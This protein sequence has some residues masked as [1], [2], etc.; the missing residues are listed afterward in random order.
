MSLSNFLERLR[1]RIL[2]RR[3]LLKPRPTGKLRVTRLE[4]RK[5][6]DAGFGFG[7]GDI[8]TLDGFTAGPDAPALVIDSA[9][10]VLTFEL[11]N[12][13]WAAG[14]LAGNAAFSLSVDNRTLS[15]DT[16]VATVSGIGVLAGD[17]VSGG[18]SLASVSNGTNGIEVSSLTITN[19]GD[20]TLNNAGNDFDTIDVQANSFTFSDTDDVIIN[21]LSVFA[22]ATL[23]AGGS[24]TDEAGST[25]SVGDDSVFSGSSITLGDSVGDSATFG[26]LK[27]VSA[28][29]VAI[30]EADD[31]DLAVGSSG[32]TVTL[33]A[34]GD[35]DGAAGT[36]VTADTV[37]FTANDA[38]LTESSIGADGQVTTD[39]TTLHASSSGSQHFGDADSVD[40]GLLS[41]NGTINLESGTFVTDS[42]TAVT[43]TIDLGSSA[44]LG[45]DGTVGDLSLTDGDFSPGNSPGVLNTGDFDLGTAANLDIELD[46]TAIGTEYDQVNVTGT[47]TLAGTLTVI[48]GFT[49][50]ANDTFTII[51][52]DDMDAVVGTF[53]GLAEGAVFVAGGEAFQISYVGVDG[54]DVVLTS[55]KHVYD[56]NA[57]NVSGSESGTISATLNRSGNT[58]VASSVEV[59]I[60]VGAGASAAETTDFT[61]ETVTV[62]FAAGATSATVDVD[63]TADTI[64]EDNE[65]VSL[66]LQNFSAGGSAGTTNASS[67]VTITNDDTAT[68]TI[69]NIAATETN[70]DQ[71]LTATVTLSA[72]V[73]G[74]ISVAYASAAVTA[75]TTDFTVAGT[76]VAFDGTAGEE[77]TISVTIGGDQIVEDNETFTIT[78][79]DVTAVSAVQDAAITTGAVSSGSIA[80]DDTATLS[81]G[82]STVNEA[83]G[84]ATFTITSSNASEKDLAFDVRLNI[85]TATGSDVTLDNSSATINGDGSTT[86]TTVTVSIADDQRVEGDENYSLTITNAKFD[87]VVDTDRVV[88]GAGAGTGDGVVT[89]NDT[90]TLS[91]DT[92]ANSVDEDNA[93]VSTGVTL[94]LNTSGTGTVG[95]DQQVSVDVDRTAGSAT[96]GG[97]EPDATYTDTTLT[98]A[99][100][101]GDSF[102]KSVD[103]TIFDDIQN[104]AGETVVL[105]LQDLT[106]GTSGQVSLGTSTHTLT[107]TDDDSA[108]AATLD[109]VSGAGDVE[110]RLDSLSGTILQVYVDGVLQSSRSLASISQLTINGTA[111]DEIVTVDASTGAFGTAI[112]F[113]GGD[114]ADIL[115]VRNPAAG[116]Y[117][118]AGGI[119]FNGND[120]AD[121]LELLGGTATTIEHQFV[122][123]SDG[124]VFYNGEA[125]ATVVYTGLAPVIDTIAATNRIFTF[126]GGAETIDVT[127]AAAVGQTTI[128]STLGESVSFVS[129]S[130][131]LTINAGTGDD[132]INITG[133][134]SL[135]TAAITINGDAGTDIINLGTDLG[136]GSATSTGEAVFNVEATNLTA[137]VTIGTNGG[138]STGDLTFTGTL[139]GAFDLTANVGGVTTFVSTVGASTALD[140]ITTDAAGSVVVGGNV[141]ANT[142]D[143][144]ETSGLSLTANAEF[145]ATTVDIE[146]GISGAFTLTLDGSTSVNVAGT[147]STTNLTTQTAATVGSVAIAG[148]LAVGGGQLTTNVGAITVGG[149][150]VSTAAISAAT[151]LSVTGTSSIGGNVTSVGEQSYSSAVTQTANAIY[152]GADTDADFEAIDFRS[153]LA[154]GG[155]SVTIVG[156]AGF[157]SAVSGVTALA[158]DHIDSE[159]TISAASVSVTGTSDLGGAVTTSG[160]QNYDGAVLLTNSVTLASTGNAAISLDSTVNGAF[161]LVVNTTGVTTFGG[162]VGG[163]SPLSSLTTNAGGTTAINGGTVTTSG[164]QSYND[165]VT[166]AA[167]TTTTGVGLTFGSTVDGNF[168]LTADGG[169]GNV[170]FAGA[171]GGVTTLSGLVVDGADVNFDSTVQIDD[172]G[173]DVDSTDALSFDAAVTTTNGGTVTLSNAGVLTLAAAAD[174]NLDGAFVQDG[175]GTVTTAADIVTSGNA[176]SFASAVTQSGA[177]LLDTTNAGTV[178]SGASIALNTIAGGSNSLTLNG[179]SAGAMTSGQISGVGS[180]TIT[181]SASAT[182]SGTVSAATVAITDTTGNVTFNDAVTATSFTAAASSFG[183]VFNA[184]GTIA[185]AVTLNN[186]GGVTFGNAVGDT[187]N[188][189]NGITS[190]ASTTTIQGTL[191]TTNSN[192]TF[193]ATTLAAAAT[194]NTGAGGGNINFGQITGGTNS[195]VVNAGTG[196]VSL[197]NAG[198]VIGGLTVTAAAAT[199]TEAD[200]ITQSAAWTTTGATTLNAG[201]NDITLTNAANQFGT[202]NLTA[203]NATIRENADIEIGSATITT[204]IDLT[205]TGAINDATTDGI[206]DITATS[207]VLT[208]ATG[209][210]SSEELEISATNITASST[211]GNIDLDSA[212]ATAVNVATLVTGSGTID[213]D[214]LGAGGVDFSGPVTSG[215]G[216]ISL[217]SDSGLVVGAVVSSAGTAGG[218]LSV[219]GATLN[220]T[221]VVG[222]DITIAGGSVDTVIAAD[223]ANAGDLALSALRDV[224]IS[225]AISTT[226]G[227]N[228]TITADSDG[229][230]NTGG[231]GSALGG[232]LIAADGQLNSAGTVGVSGSD[233]LNGATAGTGQSV[234]VAADGTND[235]IVAVGDIS[236]TGNAVAATADVVI[237]GLVTSTTGDISVTSADEIQTATKIEATAGSIDFNDAVVLTGGTTIFAGT[238]ATFDLT[239]DGAFDLSLDVDGAATFVGAVGATTAIGDGTGAAI[240]IDGDGTTEFQSAVAT[241]SGIAQANNAGAVTFRNNINAA[242]GD[243][244]SLFAG[245]VVLDGLAF[246]SGGTI[247]FGNATTDTLT[248]SA[249][250][251]SISTAAANADVVFDAATIAGAD[252]TVSVG[253]GGITVNSVV[254][255]NSNVV[256]NSAG[257]TD[258]NAAIGS[259]T[260]VGSLTTDAPGSTTLAANVTAQGGTITIN[261]ALVLNADVILA[262]SGATGIFLN[263][264]VDSDSTARDLTLTTTNAAATISIGN[265]ASD[266]VGGSSA[267]D[268]LSVSAAGT[269]VQAA[270]IAGAAELTYDAVGAILVTGSTAVAGNIDIDSGSTIG[271]SNTITTTAGGTVNIDGTGL[272][273]LSS[274]ADINSDGAVSFGAAK[275]GGLSTGGDITTTNDAITFN[276]P[277]TLTGDVILN[278]GAGI[279][280]VTFSSPNGTVNG[281]RDLTISAGTGNVE[282]DA[283]I[284]ASAALDHLNVVL[285]NQINFDAAITAATVT[286]S[287]STIDG[288]GLVAANTIDLDAVNGIGSTTAL[289][290]NAVT[291]DAT[292]TTSGVI[293]I[294]EADSVAVG[295][296][297]NGD[298]AVTL[299]AGGSVTDGNGGVTNVTAGLF[300]V[301]AAGGIDLDTNVSTLAATNT[302]SGSISIDEADGVA[303]DTINNAN[304]TVTLTAGGAITDAGDANVDIVAGTASVTITGAG[305][306]G[307]SLNSIETTVADLTTDT[308]TSGGSQFITETDGLTGININ[309][310]AGNVTLATGAAIA[311]ADAAID[312]V[313]NTA[314]L[315]AVGG[316]GSANAI[317]TNIVTLNSGNTSGGDVRIAEANDL[318]LGSIVNAADTVNIAAVGSI[319]DD[320]ANTAADISADTIQLSAGTGIGNLAEVELNSAVVISAATTAGDIDIDHSADAAVTASSLTT[321]GAGG[322]IDFDQ[323]GNHSLTLTTVSTTNGNV[324]ISN[325]GGLAAAVLVGSITADTSDD[326]VAISSSSSINDASANPDSTADIT[327]A[328]VDLNAVTGI[329]NTAHL[330]LASQTISADTTDGNIDIDNASSTATVVS[331]LTTGT[332]N[333]AFNQSGGGSVSFATATTAAGSIDL[334]NTGNDLIVATSVVAAGTGDVVLT[335]TTAGDVIVNGAVTAADDSVTIASAEAVSGAALITAAT[336]NLDANSGIGSGSAVNLAATTIA[337]DNSSADN[338]RINN[339]LATAVDVTSLT[340][341]GGAIVFD[342][343]GGGDVV[344]SGPVTSG[345]VATNGGDISLTSSAG[346]EVSATST[347][348]SAAGSGGTLTIA[349]ATVNG[350][351]T[352]GEGDVSIQ[353]GSVD[354]LVS[355][356]LTSDADITLTAERDVIIGGVVSANSGASIVVTSDTNADTDS[357]SGPA[358]GHGGVQITTAGQ[359]NA[360]GTITVTGSD[361]FATGADV[362]SVLVQADG[363]NAQVLAVGSIVIGDGSNAPVAAAVVVDGLVQT[364]GTASTIDVTSEGNVELGSFGDVQAVD[365][366]VT[367]TADTRSGNNG[368]QVVMADGAQIRTTAGDITVL[369]DGN[370]SLGQLSTTS[371]VTVTSDSGAITDAGDDATYDIIAA[372]SA[373]SALIGIGDD[374]NALETQTA[375]AAST[376]TIAALTDSGDINIA[377]AG[378]LT[379]GTVGGVVGITISDDS[380]SG[381]DAQDSTLDNITLVAASPLTVNAAITNN[382]GSNII[383]TS[384]NDGGLDDHL[385]INAALTVTG[386]DAIQDATGNI[387]LNAGTDL[388]VNSAAATDAAGTITGIAARDVQLLNTSTLTT[389][390][391]DASL[392]ATA[393][394]IAMADG[395]AL[396]S[397]TGDLDLLA[398]SNVALS[399]VTTTANVDVTA[400]TGSIADAGDSAIDVAANVA[401]FTAATGI[402]SGNALETTVA[403]LNATNSTSGTIEFAETDDLAIGIVSNG[404]RNVTISAG[405]NITDANAAVVNVTAGLF[406]VDA[407]G[408]IDLDTSISSLDASTSAAGDID[409][410]ETDAITL[411]DV[412]TADGMIRVVAAGTITA[413]DVNSAAVDDDTNDILLTTTTGDI[414]VGL[415]NAGGNNDVALTAAAAISESGSDAAVDLLAGDAELVADSGIGNGNA[416]ETTLTNLAFSNSTS[417]AVQITNSQSLT[418]A[419]VGALA[420][421]SNAAGNIELCT[422]SGDLAVNSAL[423]ATGNT[424]RLG[425]AS[426]VTQSATGIISANDLAVRATGDILLATA[427]AGNNVDD[428]FAAASTTSGQIQF[429]DNGGFTVGTV[430]AAAVNVGDCFTATVGVQTAAGDVKLSSDAGDIIVN[431]NVTAGGTGDATLTTTTS[432]NVTVT[433]VVSSANTVSINSAGEIVG[434][435]TNTAA[436]IVANTVTLTAV[437]GIGDAPELELAATNISAVSDNGNIDLDNALATATTVSNLQTGAGTIT[438][439]QSGG[440]AVEFTTVSTTDGTID[441][442]NGGSDLTVGTSVTA[443]GTGDLNLTTTGAGDVVLTGVATAADN[444]ITIN[445]ADLIVGDAADTA[446]DLVATNLDLTAVNGIGVAQPLETSVANLTFSNTSGPV[447]IANDQSLNLGA[448]TTAGDFEMCLTSG[449]LTISDTLSATGGTVRLQ[450]SAGS[451]IESGAGEILATNLGVNASGDITLGAATNAVNVFAAES[452]GGSIVFTEV[453]GFEVGFLMAGDCFDGATGVQT[454]FDTGTITL[455]SGGNLTTL[456]IIKSVN[457]ETEIN[458]TSGFLLIGGSVMT[459]G[460]AIDV[461]TVGSASVLSSVSSVSG[462]I[463]ITSTGNFVDN[464]APITT[465]SGDITVFGSLGVLSNDE[466]TSTSGDIDVSGDFI[467]QDDIFSTGV[468]GTI[469]VSATSTVL[470][471][472]GTS[473]TTDAGAIVYSSG[474]NAVISQ[475]TTGSGDIDVDAT[476][477]TADLNELIQSTTGSIDITGD[478]V[479]Q[480]ANIM[481]GGAGTIDVTADNGDITMADGTV[482]TSADGNITYDATNSIGLS[483]I[484]TAADA[485]VTA[486]SDSDNAGAITDNLTGEAAN[487]TA[488]ELALRAADGIGAADDIDTNV[489]LLAAVSESGSILL[490]EVDGSGVVIGTTDGLS[491][492]TITDTAAALDSGNDHIVV[493]SSGDIT[494]DDAVANNDHGNILLSAESAGSGIVA[495]AAISTQVGNIVLTAV[496]NVVLDESVSTTSTG[497]VHVVSSTGGI[498]VSDTDSSSSG[499]T[500]TGGAGD[501]LL[502]AATTISLGDNLDSGTGDVG[503]EAGRAFSQLANVSVTTDGGNAIVAADSISMAAGSSITTGVANGDIL[504]NSTTGDITVESLN[505]G[506]GHVAIDSAAD[507]VDQ[508]AGE[509]NNVTAATLQLTAAGS[510]GAADLANLPTANGNA[511][512]TSVDTLAATAASGIYVR[513]TNGITVGTTSTVSVTV[514]ANN[515]MLN[516]V[517]AGSTTQ[518]TGSDAATSDITTTAGPIKIVAD[519]GNITINDGD[520]DGFGINAG[521]DG[522]VLLEARTNSIVVNSDVR[523]AT[524]HMTLIAADDID[525]NEDVR[526]G[527]TGTIFLSA[528]DQLTVDDGADADTNGIVTAGGSVLVRATTA[529]VNA[530]IN[531][532]GGDFGI[533]LT[534]S[535][536][537]TGTMN[538]AGGDV[539]LT[540]G[541]DLTL[542]SLVAGTGT[543]QIEA[544]GNVIDGN[545]GTTIGTLNIVSSALRINSGRSIGSSDTGAADSVNANAIDVSVTTLA[546]NSDSGIYI[547][548]TDGLIVDAVASIAIDV[549]QVHFN[550]TD[551]A[552]NSAAATGSLADLTTATNGSI[553][554]VSLAG[555]LQLNEGGDGDGHAVSASGSGDVLIEARTAGDV[556]VSSAIESG[557]GHITLDAADDVRLN[558]TIITG[559]SGTVY[560]LAANANAA[561][562]TAA[563]VDGV[564]IAGTITTVDG[565]ILAESSNDILQ[566]ALITSTTGDVGHVATNDVVQTSSGDITTVDGDVLIDAGNDWTMDADAVITAGGQDVLGLA[567]NNITLGV[568]SLTDAGT[569][570]IALQAGADII[571]G[572]SG[573]INIQETIAAAATS[574][575]LRAGSAIGASD[576]ASGNGVDTNSNAIDLK[577]DTV[578]AMADDGIYLRQIASGGDIEINSAAAVTVSVDSVVRS[579]FNSTTTSVA[580]T[581]SEGSLESLLT[582]NTTGGAIKLVAEDGTIT[583]NESGTLPGFAVFAGA[584]GDILLE[585][586]GTNSDVIVNAQIAGSGNITLDADDDISVNSEIDAFL[587]GTIYL[588]AENQTASDAAVADGINVDSAIESSA[589]D[590]LLESSHDIRQNA[591]ISSL[592]GDIGLVSTNDITQTSTGDISTL[593]GDVLIDAGNDWTMA[594]DAII[595]AGGQ[596][597]LG[598]AGG[599]IVLGVISATDIN[600][601]HI[602]LSA[603]G[604]ITDANAGAVN[605]EET[606]ST[607]TTTLSLRAGTIVGGIGGGTATVN[608]DAIDLDI[609][610]IAASAVDGIFLREIGLGRAIEVNSVDA[611]LVDIEGIVRTN[612]DS[613]TSDVSE[614]RSIASLEDLT[615]TAGPIKL[616]AEAGAITINGGADAIGVTAGGANNVLLDAGTFNDV[617]INADVSSTG[618]HITVN[619]ADDVDVNATITTSGAGTVY[620]NAGNASAGDTAAP[621]VDGINIDGI[622]TTADGD[623]LLNSSQDIRTTQ[624]V[625]STTGDVGIIAARDIV[626]ENDGDIT[627]GGD[628]LVEAGNDWTMA[629]DAVITATGGEVDGHA[630]AGDLT[631]GLIN[632]TNVALTAEGSIIDANAGLLNVDA[633]TLSLQ[634]NTGLIGNHDNANGT[635]AAN[636]NAIDT[637]VT[638]LAANAEAGIYISEADAVVVD[639][640]NSVTVNVDAPVQVNFNDTTTAVNQSRTTAA[641]EDLTSDANGPVKLQTVAGTLTINGGTDGIGVVA[642]GTGDVLLQAVGSASDVIVNAEVASGTGNVTLNAGDDIAVNSAIT[643]TG[644]GSVFVV[645]GAATA[646]A[647]VGQVDGITLDAALTTAAGDVL[648]TSSQS[649]TINQA[650][651]S[652]TGDVG[653]IADQDITQANTGDITTGA[654]VLIEAGR[655]WTMASDAVITATGGEVDGHAI[656]GSINLGRINSTN[657]ALTAGQS[658]LD[659]NGALLNIDAT[660]VSLRADNGQVGTNADAID[661]QVTTLAANAETG[662]YILEADDLVIDTVAAVTVNVDSPL[663]VNFNSTTSDVAQ[664]RSTAVL[665]DLTTESNGPIKVVATGG[666]TVNGGTDTIAVSANGTG[667][668]LLDAN[669]GDLVINDNVQSGT[670][671]VTVE[672]A[673]QLNVGAA[674]GSPVVVQT[675]GTGSIVASAQS[676]D[677]VMQP[678]AHLSTAFGSIHI[679]AATDVVVGRITSLAN[680]AITATAGSITDADTAAD[681]FVDITANGLLLNSGTTIGDIGGDNAIETQVA[682]IAAESNGE[683]HV[684]EADALVIGSV[685]VDTQRVDFNGGT[686]AVVD[687]AIDGILSANSDILLKTGSTLDIVQQ[688]NAGSADVRIVSDATISQTAT[689]IVTADEL[690]IILTGALA[691]QNIELGGADNEL[692]VLAIRNDSEGGNATVF[693]SADDLVVGQI[694]SQPGFAV[695][696]GID[697]NAGDINI[698]AEGDLTVTEDINAA[699]QTLTTSIDESITLISRNGDFILNDNVVVTSDENPAPGEFDDVTGDQITIIAGSGGSNGVVRLGDNIEVRSDGGVAR[700]VAPRPTAFAV[701]PTTGAQSAFVTLSDAETMRSNLLF[702]NGAFLGELELV[703]GVAGE[704][705]LEVVI[706]WGVVTQTSLV[707][708]GPAGNATEI[709]PGEFAFGLDDGD[710][711]IFFIDEG[712]AAYTIPHLYDPAELL[713]TAN[714]RNGRQDNPNIVGVRFSVAQHESINIWGENA[715]DPAGVPDTTPPTF[716]QPAVDDAGNPIVPDQIAD[717]TGT[718]IQPEG[719]LALLSSTD[720]N[721]L[722]NFSQEATNQSLP[723]NDNRVVTSTGRPEGQAEW[724][725]LAG[726]SPGLVPVQQFAQQ[727]FDAPLVETP[728]IILTATEVPGDINLGDGAAGD[729]AVGTEVYLQIR[730]HFESDAEAEVVIARIT[731]NSFIANRDSFED[732][733]EQNPVLQ[734]GDGYEVWLITETGG[735][736]VARPIVE[737]EITGGRPGPATEELPDTFEPYELKE[738]EFEQPVEEPTEEQQQQLD[739]PADQPKQDEDLAANKGESAGHDVAAK[740]GAAETMVGQDLEVHQSEDAERMDS[741]AVGIIPL[742]GLSRAARWKRRQQAESEK[743]GRSSRTARRM[744]KMNETDTGEITQ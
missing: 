580:E 394:Q 574:V 598:S 485:I 335:T 535:G 105:S 304:R 633:T 609:D 162:V 592:D 486:D 22:D 285:A 548:E 448:A 27:F 82:N 342:Q 174:F 205:S 237:N 13:I 648:L 268:Q 51:N 551:T 251:V 677:V 18:D 133:I 666:L 384:T 134:D 493:R 116:V 370:V 215:G 708:S 590:I 107:I 577:V 101:D 622:I 624:L 611:V 142:I 305:D 627:T 480:D 228:I 361:V 373:L 17:G 168:L 117:D 71:N 689:G 629:A 127:D 576:L 359:L 506:T 248:T 399:S 402:G 327:S 271:I 48:P 635:P 112:I 279:G 47:V 114:G 275:V 289:N 307:T 617:I 584:A 200:D 145:D 223:L 216:A 301:D 730:R 691:D 630:V 176:I 496:D 310:G 102:T 738:L 104:D 722:R 539:L 81:I 375:A 98:F 66:T 393:G 472:A 158:A 298:R 235:Q 23:T 87:G 430:A 222:A 501:I 404:V 471:G 173:L 14:D 537:L 379:V 390:D 739:E 643:T 670:G 441:L 566:T 113:N 321:G 261:D 388:I 24:I 358:G 625:N 504:L 314:N 57:A 328:V 494:V 239:V 55:A 649:I 704:E 741:A 424:I 28:G 663:Q 628:V 69:S 455:T 440:G 528:V 536:G 115:R 612:F 517:D 743:F 320:S 154:G 227:G 398:Q 546:A 343:A 718:F 96:I 129:P 190:T 449:D 166:L 482:T 737:F 578:A 618:G 492:I 121:T 287:G 595:T 475:L 236:V 644:A 6:L 588:L 317:Q 182:F 713:T 153:T 74:G 676:A 351:V 569:N 309:A 391:G 172:E 106:D 376:H 341:V 257:I 473:A 582:T 93:T 62:N 198:N 156:G 461:N 392:T 497:S 32:S 458:V 544:G 229:I 604:S 37:A 339:V 217:T 54:N 347:V 716:Q 662:I 79:G 603:G 696:T 282:F 524:G 659:A 319:N 230:A 712:G 100:G 667:N 128:D 349:G 495:N 12:D 671:H 330:E 381:S 693:E 610:T 729:S 126:T 260:A 5:L 581:R 196:D 34:E 368:G 41:S 204:T 405:G 355:A 701:A 602:A 303:L 436:D 498:S 636:V 451:V 655:D 193:G 130:A 241:A 407:A 638:T 717:A 40:L 526:T 199:I 672:A 122:N 243:T 290:L 620:V 682:T 86:T 39:A 547:Q 483:Q 395:T 189:T 61:A 272:T 597:V 484:T 705:N 208:A 734:D 92:A 103:A 191:N 221:P 744:R 411:T 465:D 288:N 233:L 673:N 686:T 553:K 614:D 679:D 681:S 427:T 593:N 262:D 234:L 226:A 206:T 356:A 660:T 1:D 109:L 255:G 97:A 711:S 641:L 489:R 657:V 632:S 292:N 185:N 658:I 78:L 557:T 31:I 299:D 723:L 453:D 95:L 476:A 259:T 385:T 647:G 439:D 554:V 315:T 637:Q 428:V 194:V 59:V 468:S 155:N 143:L 698:T 426:N 550:S 520:A 75:E 274:A 263:N 491:G 170:V 645:S 141:S 650:I 308:S 254:D 639:S 413:V 466:I 589:G 338:V 510:I 522:D 572:N 214:H 514:D 72:A 313:A 434:D 654:D 423:T 207:V 291:L 357:G 3:A 178:V 699:H 294:N 242:A 532:A 180:L 715:T 245:D 124:S 714:D 244:G 700:Q 90:A 558:S 46:G 523:S 656:S 350:S 606:F 626:Q 570:R 431:D 346:L 742:L 11:S 549:Q 150:L 692:S 63:I 202:L 591:L 515:L 8:L 529:T 364:T 690:G 83:A 668:I 371:T 387:D 225:G 131:Q 400:T 490:H 316:I 300:T 568:I 231:T 293:D 464:G 33:T 125:T 283:A 731:D 623:V 533:E 140:V 452:T 459:A 247:T 416:I 703:F 478:T 443:G 534:G 616:V 511:I 211:T 52:N 77:E 265:A 463:D 518:Q 152:T 348:S 587:D 685:Q 567:G 728:A 201:V 438:F 363:V 336:V 607:S 280:T 195:L 401:S 369:A 456:G 160:L 88:I 527:G 432:G 560:F 159:S 525:L 710:K 312:L 512:N 186:T 85:G 640:V 332:G 419:A 322:T 19:G 575:S 10:G 20:V 403:T 740:S 586:R 240:S 220:V 326:I 60:G 519:A 726:P 462:D 678:S 429:A 509:T 669:G 445:S 137:D 296:I 184:G 460:G 246:T 21:G 29:D 513:E 688:L 132:T 621:E 177:V 531:T 409:I 123:N 58:S 197:A 267:L 420:A 36:N 500:A 171:I 720:P 601:N 389:V 508:A 147:I 224:L 323:S 481:T 329:G 44:V 35:I 719:Q 412:D 203:A 694:S 76:S 377:N 38:G 479:T 213:F 42:S 352:V 594:G 709:N 674:T 209:V 421:S 306:F 232:V 596:Q 324:S 187:I 469:T 695:T 664:S 562:A 183:V 249:A 608:D 25:I 721:G 212:L 503:I 111:T 487:I 545:D 337:A 447:Q 415:V 559:G 192:V 437:N 683:I 84:T 367:I 295:I 362:D 65:L 634:A 276:T 383:L 146:S 50:A 374:A 613:S 542:D 167:N 507:I 169:A 73:E 344:F 675:G 631:L 425:A 561:D 605:V 4:E 252:L 119:T 600:E 446:A 499:I 563:N 474:G 181:D 45:G 735:Q 725:F 599:D 540:A 210:G 56:F 238:N 302:V 646:D 651:N 707:D 653:L 219:S 135:M 470:M 396:Q 410:N 530:D 144:N 543:V 697:T 139:D 49:P 556:I 2:K 270:N 149:N 333:I 108:S 521:G 652:T 151:S 163:L 164:A 67:T 161:A 541:G 585:A 615:T 665:E 378:S 118:P 727:A 502:Q 386:G 258:I 505:A 334:E 360:A 418:V 94:T 136:L 297:N 256:Y 680:V 325:T 53:A 488:Y 380:G 422:T 661:T 9:P 218:T 16:G 91:F 68:L 331:S 516:G 64:V 565:D 70:A 250:A 188:F 165:A 366:T 278:T 15:V 7:V 571:D 408:G 354:L 454:S 555:D 702:T 414:V 435:S 365:G 538:T 253:T 311:D 281:T 30:S 397:T 442:E 175:A 583:V 345:A 564:N 157:A 457:G 552:V 687:A 619:A 433:A 120:G 138:G 372:N 382:D 284:G 99:A 724:E 43:G 417:G 80:N 736:K 179:G 684:D 406:T 642:N 579:N 269:V 264:T 273:T 286:A 573:S 148:D 450:T 89:D 318:L 732:F 26:T 467:L 277:V 706:D 110:V 340:T 266:T 733:V 444:T 477:G 353:G